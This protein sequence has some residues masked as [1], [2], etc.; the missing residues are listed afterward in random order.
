MQ[1]EPCPCR[2]L[3]CKLYVGDPRH[4]TAT[5]YGN[6]RCRCVPCTGAWATYSV[7]ARTKRRTEKLPVGDPRHGTDN[8]YT[9]Y[10]CRASDCARD[11][12]Y[13]CRQARADSRKKE[14]VA[15]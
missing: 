4:G 11:G 1:P 2:G 5:G 6:N 10:N 8:G 13:G 15:A 12:T 7:T 14:S 9:N 3:K